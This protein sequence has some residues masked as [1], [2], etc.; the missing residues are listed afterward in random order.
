MPLRRCC[1]ALISHVDA[2]LKPAAPLSRAPS[3]T[4]IAHFLYLFFGVTIHNMRICCIGNPVVV[5]TS[6]RL[7]VQVLFERFPDVPQHGDLRTLDLAQAVKGKKIDVI[8]ISTPCVD[9]SA[10]GDRLAQDGQESNLFFVALDVIKRYTENTSHIPVIVS[11]NVQGRRFRSKPD[12]GS[13]Y[14]QPFLRDEAEALRQAGYQELGWREICSSDA[15][16]P[17]SKRH[18]YLVAAGGFGASAV[19][20]SCLFSS[21]RLPA[22]SPVAYAA[23]YT[24]QHSTACMHREWCAVMAATR[25]AAS[26]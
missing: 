16:V 4:I 3:G 12:G 11:E 17:H 13:P 9:L 14:R 1:A 15:G 5:E 24:V 6:H 26:A 25:A 23:A 2:A 7:T 21:V 8:L 18:V 10:R 19:V 22:W 20:E